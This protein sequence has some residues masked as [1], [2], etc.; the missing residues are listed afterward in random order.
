MST[1]Y[2]SEFTVFSYFYRVNSLTYSELQEMFYKINEK[3]MHEK[4]RIKEGQRYGF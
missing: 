1:P 2:D 3:Q 4:L